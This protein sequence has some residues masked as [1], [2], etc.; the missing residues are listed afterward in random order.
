MKTL[1]TEERGEII[2]FYLTPLFSSM[3]PELIASVLTGTLRDYMNTPGWY[4]LD[5]V[6][7]ANAICAIGQTARLMVYMKEYFSNVND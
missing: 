5:P 2:D 3:E 4:K 6:K 1:S 7:Q